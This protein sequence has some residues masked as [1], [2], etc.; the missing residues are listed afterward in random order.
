MTQILIKKQFEKK[1]IRYAAAG[2]GAILFILSLVP[3]LVLG[4][5]GYV[6]IHDQLDGEV[7]AYVLTAKHLK[8]DSIPE[9]MSGVNNRESLTPASW[10][11]L[12]FYLAAAPETAFTLNETFVRII[13][14]IGMYLLLRKWR[15]QKG[16]AYLTAFLF[17]LLNFYSVYGLA[18]MGQPLLLYGFL[19]AKDRKGG[20]LPYLIPVLFA[21]FSSPVLVGYADLAVLGVTLIV[22]LIRRKPGR[23]AAGLFILLMAA[24]YGILYRELFAQVLFGTSFVTHRTEWILTDEG[25]WGEQFAS[26]FQNGIYH[27]Q[28][29]QNT[30]VAWTLAAAGAGALLYDL[31]DERQKGVTRRLWGVLAGAALVGVIF[32]TWRS[33]PA[34]SARQQAGGLFVAFRLERFYWLNPLL[35]WAA[36]GLTLQMMKE[37]ASLPRIGQIARGKVSRIVSAILA[38]VLAVSATVTIY[39][40]S[41]LKQNLTRLSAGVQDTDI[42]FRNFYSENLFTKIE[43]WIGKSKDE[44]KVGSIALYP[45]VALYN[46]FYCID[47]YSNNYDVEYKHAFRE[48][49]EEML[50]KKASIRT[51][52]DEWG[53][54]C[55]LFTSE[56]GKSYW[57]TKNSKRELKKLKL[58]AKA[59]SSLG[60]QYIFSGLKIKK[61]SKSGLKFLKSFKMAGSP[62]KIWLYQVTDSGE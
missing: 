33:E 49:I 14:F 36:F 18:V 39:D 24:T 25:T 21:L 31:W 38:L 29:A 45:S 7:P 50:A 37:A 4:G 55:Y 17:S 3:S 35:W 20:V 28:A 54:R 61:P 13:A 19:Q 57:F 9:L 59:L 6:I 44:Y 34:L 22:L 11:T 30:F 16:I 47:G 27:A 26:I 1:W 32:A 53:N 40:A 48:T 60:C 46:G 58:N 41:P 52:F 8:D 10:G 15:V 23:L 42:S 5:D 2:L 51:Y 12:L 62:Y 43:K 56:L